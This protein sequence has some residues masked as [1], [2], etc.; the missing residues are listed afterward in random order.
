MKKI[1]IVAI[2]LIS[3]LSYGQKKSKL[4]DEEY[5]NKYV[6][7]NLN[8]FTFNGQKPVGSGWTILENLFAENQFVAWGEYHNSPVVSQLTSF[9]L[10]SA[11]HNGFKFW[12]VETSPFMASELMRIAKTSNPIETILKLPRIAP[13]SVS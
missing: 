5:F 13:N 1:L 8:T 2:L 9:A 4:T 6:T 7:E 3:F 10:E 11:S 12:C